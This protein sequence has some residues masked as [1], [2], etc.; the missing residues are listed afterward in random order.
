MGK[1]MWVNMEENKR[2]YSGA[3]AQNIAEWPRLVVLVAI[4]EEVPDMVVNELRRF[5]LDRLFQKTKARAR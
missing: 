1:H 3:T 5:V 4:C 2:S